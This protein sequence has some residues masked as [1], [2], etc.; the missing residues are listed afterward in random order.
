MTTVDTRV[1]II[2][3]DPVVG[4]ALEVLLQAAGYRT[5]FLSESVMDDLLG[6]V[7]PDS[8]LL[9]IAPLLSAERRKAV[10]KMMQDPTRPVNIPVLQLLPANGGEHLQGGRIL[11]W[12]CSG[13]EL[14]RAIDALLFD[15]GRFDRHDRDPP[16]SI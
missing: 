15:Q 8:Q 9:L 2:G 6:E 13:E 3:G 16:L 5:Q 1:T 10:L 14:K 12:P 11:L 7:L 4:E